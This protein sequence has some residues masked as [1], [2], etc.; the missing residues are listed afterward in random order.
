MR[1]VLFSDFADLEPDSSQAGYATVNPLE[2]L[3][4]TTSSMF[5]PP[6]MVGLELRYH[7]GE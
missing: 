1:R 3:M 6:R 7:L 4:F 5:A 2:H